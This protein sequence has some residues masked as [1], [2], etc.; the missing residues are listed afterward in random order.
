[1][2]SEVNFRAA[3]WRK[4]T[5]CGANGTCVEIAGL[6]GRTVAIRD[7]TGGEGGPVLVLSAAQWRAFLTGVRTGGFELL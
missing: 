2:R 5:S 4:S 7:S 1:M 3:R 6:P